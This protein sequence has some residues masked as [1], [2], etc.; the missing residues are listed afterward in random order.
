MK[1]E[2]DKKSDKKDD[3]SKKALFIQR[4]IAFLIDSVIVVFAASLLSTPFINSGKITDLNNK[5]VELMEKYKAGKISNNEYLAEYMNI[6]YDTAK[7]EGIVSLISVI[8]GLIVFVIIPLY[9]KGQTIGKRI[10]RIKIVSDT[11]ELTM[12]Q[13]IFRS[14]I[15]NSVLINLI[16][17]IL[18]M[19]LSKNNYFYC[20]GLFIIIQYVI[21]ALSVFLIM[22]RKDGKAVHDLLVK[23]QVVKI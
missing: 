7:N 4:L 20:Y 17:V 15:A 16:S 9:K 13:L 2:S 19:F 21:T 1:N 10:L 6:T 22:C 23:T 11:G 3:K 8:L 14:F 12:N 18:M 5:S